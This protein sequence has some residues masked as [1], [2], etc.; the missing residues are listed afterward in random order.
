M[1]AWFRCSHILLSK[2]CTSLVLMRITMWRSKFQSHR[3]C[4]MQQPYVTLPSKAKEH[5]AIEAF[6]KHFKT[7]LEKMEISRIATKQTL[8]WFRS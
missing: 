8:C 5:L 6:G 1:A 4:K 7:H 3:L 2:L